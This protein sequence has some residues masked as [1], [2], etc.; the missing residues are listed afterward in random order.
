MLSLNNLLVI[1]FCLYSYLMWL[2]HILMNLFQCQRYVWKAT[3]TYM[4][5]YTLSHTGIIYVL[6]QALLCCSLEHYRAAAQAFG[7]LSFQDRSVLSPW[8]WRSHSLNSPSLLSSI[9][10]G[11]Y[12]CRGRPVLEV[13]P[14]VSLC[15]SFQCLWLTFNGEARV[16]RAKEHEMRLAAGAH[17]ETWPL[18]ASHLHLH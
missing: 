16:K 10:H 12:K 15:Q 8:Q 13:G 2:V 9:F 3:H 1:Q 7:K 11:A 4:D 6:R 14:S 17:S 5:A 18:P